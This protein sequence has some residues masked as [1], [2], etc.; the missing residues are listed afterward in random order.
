M[1]QPASSDDSSRLAPLDFLPEDRQVSLEER[2]QILRQI[3]WIVEEERAP[4]TPEAFQ[5]TPRKIGVLFPALVNLAAAA[6]VAGGI[7][8]LSFY[9]QTRKDDLTL[10]LSTFQSAEGR[11][12]EA[13]QRRSES[14]L[15]EKERQILQ[16]QERFRIAESTFAERLQARAEELRLAMEK[17]LAEERE[18]LLAQR[19]TEAE[20]KIRLRELE[21]QHRAANAAALARYEKELE[22]ERLARERDRERLFGDRILA[23]YA[24]VARDL[25]HDDLPAARQSLQGLKSL[26]NDPS[27][28]A[29]PALKNR[30]AIDLFLAEALAELA[31]R[32][33][34]EAGGAAKAGGEAV[35]VVRQQEPAAIAQQPAPAAGEDSE[36]AIRLQEAE[37]DLEDSR[38]RLAER[39]QQ[40][41]ELQRQQRAHSSDAEASQTRNARTIDELRQRNERLGAQVAAQAEKERDLAQ[42]ARSAEERASRQGHEAALKE[43]MSFLDYLTRGS[44]QKKEIQTQLLALAKRD[45]LYGA[46]VREIQI[47]AAGAGLSGASA[48]GGYKILGT[49]SSVGAGMVI[50][51]P[52]VELTVKPGARVQIRR[53]SDLENVQIIARGIVQQA[54]G[55]RI[56]ILLDSSAKGAQSPAVADAVYVE[57]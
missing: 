3:E 6:L 26:L 39:E 7:L 21:V 9:F 49:V 47:L 32:R 24:Q 22:L 50:V 46:V 54:D 51:E 19:A 1:A 57:R 41:A 17:A 35:A 5:Y 37:Q 13:Y 36:L 45:P 30:R 20:I 40:I 42:Q 31:D 15:R 56:T 55:G 27:L 28:A 10:G 18:R 43:V 14:L 25:R 33:S 53:T 52:L 12:L 38:S 11:L 8:V 23:A 44:A 4:V 48:A 29:V 34:G 2:A 16:A